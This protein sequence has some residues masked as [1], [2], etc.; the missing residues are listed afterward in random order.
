M[1]Y[2]TV[3]PCTTQ[4]LPTLPISK[5]SS[6]IPSWAT[7][8]GPIKPFPK[9]TLLPT[10]ALTPSSQAEGESGIISANQAIEIARSYLETRYPYPVQVT[11][12]GWRLSQGN[13]SYATSNPYWLVSA[14][15]FFTDPAACSLCI[16]IGFAY[17]EDGTGRVSQYSCV[18]VGGIV[19]IDAVTGKVLTVD[20]K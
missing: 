12:T 10:P 14:D 1:P 15:G 9:P 8:I 2:P 3:I 11:I 19:V 17:A 13:P 5:D 7:S 20:E 18:P 6:S 4:V 16:G